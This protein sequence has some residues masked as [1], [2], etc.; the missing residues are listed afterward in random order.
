LKGLSGLLSSRAAVVADYGLYSLTNLL[1]GVSVARTADLATYGVYALIF[2]ILNF[3]VVMARATI[4]ETWLVADEALTSSG[5]GKGSIGPS[6]FA[7]AGGA[8][9]V[10]VLLA[11]TALVTELAGHGTLAL[12]MILA[13]PA[14]LGQDCRRF[15]CF[16]SGKPCRALF[17]DGSWLATQSLLLVAMGAGILPFSPASAALAWTVG[18]YVGLFTIGGLGNLGPTSVVSGFRWWRSQLPVGGH[19]AAETVGTGMV[20]P[21]IAVG[22]VLM[23]REVTLGILRGASTLF[24]PVLVFSQGMRTALTKRARP[25]DVEGLGVTRILMIATC[26]V[27]G[28]VLTLVP[29]VGAFILGGLWGSSISKI[30]LLEAAA[31]I[32]LASASVDSARLRRSSATITA[33]KL[34][35]MTGGLVVGTVLLG[36]LVADFVGAATGAAAAYLL[37]AMA[38]RHLSRRGD[39][40]LVEA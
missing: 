32:G 39:Y 20:G 6:A 12:V 34:G 22:L 4:G 27:W 40:H 2:Q 19:L 5:D 16:A 21:L 38:W 14:L 24:S 30:V 37:A 18:A 8:G 28:G 13:L 17:S 1:V 10:P 23:N 29:S 9:L 35:V 3:T 25:G 33:A 26:A 11:G 7:F 36:T 15:V 31:R